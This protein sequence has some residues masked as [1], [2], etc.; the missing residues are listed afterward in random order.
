MGV[1]TGAFL[2]FSIWVSVDM[3]FAM[4]RPGGLGAQELSY[5]QKKHDETKSTAQDSGVD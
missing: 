5:L 3:Y 4:K 2:A 1:V